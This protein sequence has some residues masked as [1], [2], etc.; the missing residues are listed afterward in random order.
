MY[1][2]VLA[3][4]DGIYGFSGIDEGAVYGVS[5]GRVAAAVSD[6]PNR[7]VRPE[8]RHLAAHEQ[9]LRRL[10][11]ANTVLPM[12][13]GTIADGTKAVQDILSRNGD[14][15][16]DQLQRVAAKAEMGLR[17]KW[18]VPNIF[19]YF[20]DTHPELQAARDIL[21]GR[22]RTPSHDDKIEL[23]RLFDRVLQEDREAHTESVEEV[24]RPHCFEIKRNGCRSE[25]EV[26]NLA[27]LVGRDSQAAFQEAVFEA[28]KL[29]D[30]NFAFDYSG[31]WAPHNFVEVALEL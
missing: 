30:N 6:V 16:L 17:V 3:S 24:L 13:F 29:F 8:R 1:A 15:F 7:K 18:D 11:E 21:F 4:G 28:A 22:N 27:C 26:M 5:D 19:Q 14:V 23:G 20:V 9:V 31:P 2:I 10:M 12:R 25:E